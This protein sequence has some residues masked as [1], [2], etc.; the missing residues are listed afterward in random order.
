MDDWVLREQFN[1]EIV[2]RQDLHD[3]FTVPQPI[4]PP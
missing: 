4:A 3:G 1:L 2:Q